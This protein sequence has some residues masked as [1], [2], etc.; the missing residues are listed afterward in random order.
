MVYMIQK[1]MKVTRCNSR[2][3]T[4]NNQTPIKIILSHQ[5]C[6]PHAQTTVKGE[7]T[8]ADLKLRW[9]P[10]NVLAEDFCWEQ[11][12]WSSTHKTGNMQKLTAEEQLI[13]NVNGQYAF[14]MQSRQKEN[15]NVLHWMLI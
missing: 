12:P 11:L 4:C 8:A 14:I 15:T 5:S 1:E 2:P 3:D 6:C 10:A 13:V 9:R 7:L